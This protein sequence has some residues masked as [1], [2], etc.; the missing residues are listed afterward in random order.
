M[1]LYVKK[2]TIRLFGSS[3]GVMLTEPFSIMELCRGDEVMVEVN[4]NKIM[5]IKKV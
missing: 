3:H 1:S 2:H 5:T 4:E